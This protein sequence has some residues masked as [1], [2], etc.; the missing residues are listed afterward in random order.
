MRTYR[1]WLEYEDN[2]IKNNYGKVP[3][4]EI[5]LNLDRTYY[6]INHRAVDKFN[7]HSKLG[8]NLWQNWEIDFLIENRKDLSIRNL[9]QVLKNRGLK[10]IQRKCCQLKLKGKNIGHL[11]K[12]H[13]KK[14][15]LLQ[16][17]QR[18]LWYK[19]NFEKA[20]LKAKKVQQSLKGKTWE[21]HYG[22]EKANNL[23]QKMIKRLKN[24][25]PTKNGHTEKTKLLQ[26]KLAFERF[27][28]NPEIIKKIKLARMNQI[29]PK[30]DTK[31]E[32][33]IKNFLEELKIDYF[34]HKYIKE[35]EHGYQCDF[36]IPSLNM[37][38]E[39]DGDY[40]HKYPIGKDIDKIRTSELFEKGFRVLRLW[41]HEIKIMDLKKFKEKMSFEDLK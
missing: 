31:I 17:K 23:K 33:K 2:Y 37:V 39:C 34:Q 35:I 4:L 10:E 14:S 26:S 32:I 36:F 1:K 40:W 7:L 22:I 27:E 21:D 41:E 28:R 15:K 9:H 16:S 8:Y 29:F 5:A 13:S 38:I 12:K 18:K 25:N 3:I 24:N 19:N 30:K 6:S 11:G 20:I